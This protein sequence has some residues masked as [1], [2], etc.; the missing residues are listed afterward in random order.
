M[1]WKTKW[2][3]LF[4][5]VIDGMAS[6]KQS[7]FATITGRF[8]GSR[9]PMAH[10]PLLFP[11]LLVPLCT[12]MLPGS[13]SRGGSAVAQA[14]DPN[15]NPS[16]TPGPG[17]PLLP[18]PDP[19]QDQAP[20]AIVS[21]TP[22]SGPAGTPVAIHGSHLTGATEAD[23]GDAKASI[24]VTSDTE[25]HTAVPADAVAGSAPVVVVTPAGTSSPATFTVTEK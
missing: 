5:V 7:F 16:P 14:Q 1:E 2:F 25:A 9:F 11:I 21:I 22:G 19:D 24:T 20:P 17:S 3:I 15:P 6:L 13:A 12:G 10:R 23:F 8:I 18:S 4:G